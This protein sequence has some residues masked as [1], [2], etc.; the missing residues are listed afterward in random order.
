MGGG[1]IGSAAGR[2]SAALAFD[3]ETATARLFNQTMKRNTAAKSDICTD[4]ISQP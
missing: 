3:C 1:L 4:G 2:E